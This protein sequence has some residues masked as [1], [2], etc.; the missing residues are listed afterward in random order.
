MAK[1]KRTGC[2]KFH[3]GETLVEANKSALTSEPQ[4]STFPRHNALPAKGR[5]DPKQT[6]CFSWRLDR[7]K[8]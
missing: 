4:V 1:N 2:A 3:S 8:E 5:G 7:R 6:P